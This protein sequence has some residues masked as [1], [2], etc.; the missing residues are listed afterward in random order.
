VQ[1]NNQIFQAD[2]GVGRNTHFQTTFANSVRFGYNYE[3]VDNNQGA[4]A[5]VPEAGDTSLGT[6]PGR[7]APQV[8]IGSVT[9]PGRGRR[10]VSLFLS[11]NTFQIYDDAFVNKGTHTIKFGLAVERMELEIKAL[12]DPNG[13]FKFNNLQAF[14][15]KSARPVSRGNCQ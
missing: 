2:C 5:L 1:L 14:L 8:F 4:K 10:R 7:T 3:N 15:R 11:L 12:S 6:F 9:F 13:I